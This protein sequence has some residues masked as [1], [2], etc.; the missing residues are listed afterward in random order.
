MNN[1]D[2]QVRARRK[3]AFPALVAA[4][5]IFLGSWVF[6]GFGVIAI[7]SLIF[8]L[9]IGWYFLT[10]RQ[11]LERWQEEEGV[12]TSSNVVPVGAASEYEFAVPA[13]LGEFVLD[14]NS[15][16][17]LAYPNGQGQL[18]VFAITASWNDADELL[19][20]DL[21][22]MTSAS[23]IA[24]NLDKFKSQVNSLLVNESTRRDMNNL[25]DEIAS[26]EVSRIS[27]LWSE[28]PQEA[29][30]HFRSNK[31]HKAWMCDFK[32]EQPVEGSLRFDT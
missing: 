7:F 25:S 27:F 18:P 28:R 1:I 4:A 15:E 8:L 23:E 14:E 17:W 16:Q 21:S 6:L 11:K 22:L 32:D 5:I 20:P 12:V 3:N 30:V 10:I 24:A 31:S 2:D 13:E 26:L 9:M 19:Q 29:V